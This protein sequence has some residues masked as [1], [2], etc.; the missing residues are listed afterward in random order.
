MRFWEI[1]KF[2]VY[3]SATIGFISGI[4]LFSTMYY[5][6][7]Q[8]D[9]T[10]KSVGD[11]N[12]YFTTPTM[13]IGDYFGIM[14]TFLVGTLFVI[15]TT[16]TAAIVLLP[17]LVIVFHVPLPLAALLQTA[18]YFEYLMGWAQWRSGRS[19]RSME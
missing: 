2:I 18:I 8:T 10:T 12:N 16:V 9:I 4:S 14:V 1:T 15:F 7:P 11:L 6:A 19:G 3:L 5:E 17:Y 13:G